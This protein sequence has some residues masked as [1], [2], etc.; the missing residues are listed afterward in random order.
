MDS[1]TPSQN[2]TELQKANKNKN[3]ASLGDLTITAVQQLVVTN[4]NIN[5]TVLNRLSENGFKENL[6]QE[7]KQH[8]LDMQSSSDEYSH[9]DK[10]KINNL[11]N[12]NIFTEVERFARPLRDSRKRTLFMLFRTYPGLKDKED[13]IQEALSR[14]TQ[15]QL[16]TVR[17]G[18]RDM[19][20]FLSRELGISKDELLP[21][22]PKFNEIF[23]V[24]HL[25][26]DLGNRAKAE[27]ALF[28]RSGTPL[29]RGLI[30]E[31]LGHFGS[32]GD[33]I[34]AFCK[35]FSIEFSI[36]DALTLGLLRNDDIF[37]IAESEY[38]YI[39]STLSQTE[40]EAYIVLLKTDDSFIMSIDELE[41]FQTKLSTY[42]SSRS[43]KD[44]IADRIR[45]TFDEQREKSAH[46]SILE[47]VVPDSNG[48]IHQSF[49]ELL[50][51]KVNS[52]SPRIQGLANF[53]KGTVLAFKNRAG[54][55]EFIELMDVDIELSPSDGF[56]G[57]KLRHL[58]SFE[59]N[60]ISDKGLEQ[61]FS[62]D[63]LEKLL[64]QIQ[65][66]KILK[67]DD[68]LEKVH[69]EEIKNSE[70]KPVEYNPL[71][72]NEEKKEFLIHELDAIDLNGKDL[73]FEKD[74]IFTANG[75]SDTGKKVEGQSFRVIDIIE[76]SSTSPS[77]IRFTNGREIEEAS[78]STFIEAAKNS[79][80]KRIVKFSQTDDGFLHALEAFGVAHGSTIKEGKI[81]PGSHDSHDDH[82][83]S[84]DEH[85][86]GH[87]SKHEP[88]FEYFESVDGDAHTRLVDIDSRFVTIWEWSG[89]HSLEKVQEVK[90]AK[91]L[92]KKQEKSLYTV[93]T[94]T[95]E[96]F[97][98]YLKEN[99]LKATTED[100]L[101]P[102]AKYHPHNPH[103][104]D[105]LFGSLFKGVSFAD[106]SKGFE[107][108]IHGFQHYFEKNSK[109]NAS[110]FALKVGRKLGFPQDLMAQLQADEVVSVKEI[111]DKIQEKLSNLNGPVARVKAL[112]IAQLKTSSPEEIGAAMLYMVKGYGHLYAEDIAYAQKSET[113][114]NGF[115]YSLGWTTNEEITKM[116]NDARAKFKSEG[117]DESGSEPTEEEMIWNLLKII[118]GGAGRSTSDDKYDPRFANAGT[119]V[120]AMGGPSGWEKAWRTEGSENAYQKGIRQGGDVVNAQGRVNKG[121]SSFKTHEFNT[122]IGFMEKAAGKTPHPKYQTIPVIWA[123][124][125]YSRYISTKMAQKVKGYG[126]SM[127]HTFHAY[128]FIRNS[129]DND[130][131]TDT[132]I[133]AFK[134][135]DTEAGSQVEKYIR[136]LREGPCNDNPSKKKKFEEAIDGI[137]T[138]WGKYYD[139]GL[140]DH[141]QGKDSWLINKVNKGDEKVTKYAKRFSEIH[142]MNGGETIPSPDNDWMVQYGYLHSPMLNLLDKKVN[143]KQVLS[144]DRMLKKIPIDNSGYDL[145]D[146]RKDR[147]WPAIVNTIEALRG[148]SDEEIKKAQYTQYRNDIIKFFRDKLSIRTRGADG[149]IEEIKRKSFYPDLVKLGIDPAE[150]FSQESLTIHQ[151]RDYSNWMRNSMNTQGQAVGRV[152]NFEAMIQDTLDKNS[153]GF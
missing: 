137:A 96:Q 129:T 104:H 103:M 2:P 50:D 29:S 131:Y 110:R 151:E 57:V 120:K 87:E 106:M 90:Q 83:D 152:R 44:G 4:G 60:Q 126:D 62:Y 45:Q 32:H 108:I 116:K 88:L 114:I 113:F 72:E 65:S 25:P 73:G 132:F 99:K 97:V 38:S 30:R 75:Q 115:L 77:Q 125:G 35:T 48:K 22:K 121:I 127:G 51:E 11:S 70:G 12:G 93:R 133:E 26:A 14:L 79:S 105:S 98:L 123:L 36:K 28:E 13:S 134:D 136:T 42:V 16:T 10:Q 122:V 95:R 91:N 7:I 34:V 117:G 149:A 140:H 78:F 150:F 24:E 100:L 63:N 135:I 124:G 37:R 86:H 27:I 66:G 128:S 20:S 33:K 138:L 139:K 85:G 144:V 43:I 61:S 47:R 64:V 31:V 6:I 76:G 56:T 142:S 69:N 55:L 94:M 52:A 74:V 18:K 102:S 40:K 3:S 21:W 53:M 146:D 15:P 107:N 118:D 112:H 130:T 84:H 148:E 39:W 19:L 5:P 59:E 1:N 9:I 23:D 141:L 41:R 17:Q 8:M 153:L 80:F 89:D 111:I 92:S 58:N 46:A 147:L 68:F 109:L 54:S 81:I 119:V 67:K 101:D 71:K 49:I 143:G 82:H 145:K